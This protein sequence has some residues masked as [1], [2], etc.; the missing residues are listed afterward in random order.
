MLPGA[1]TGLLQAT[2]MGVK[3]VLWRK[4]VR[5]RKKIGVK[6]CDVEK[7]NYLCTRI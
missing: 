5:R 3:V 2:M 7:N 1:F 6:F 4:I